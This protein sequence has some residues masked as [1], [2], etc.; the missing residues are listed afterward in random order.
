MSTPYHVVL[1]TTSSKE[2]VKAIVDSVLGRKLAACI[3]VIP[4]ESH[5]VWEGKINNDS[6]FLLLLKSKAADF[7]DLQSAIEAVHAYEVPEI[8][9]LD[10][11]KGS[12]KYLEWIKSVTR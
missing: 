12:S 10:V 7:S 11:E 6:E 8:I 3:Q 5:Y 1:T 2:N 9:S 4:M